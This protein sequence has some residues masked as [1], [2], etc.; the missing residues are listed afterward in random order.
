MSRGEMVVSV[1]LAADRRAADCKYVMALRRS[2]PEVEMRAEKTSGF[3]RSCSERAI[4]SRRFVED[5]SSRGLKRNLEHREARGSMILCD[6]LA[7][8]NVRFRY[9]KPH[10]P[11]NIIA[12]QAKTGY[13]CIRLHDSPKCS[14]GVLCHTVCFVK[15]NNFVGRTW[16]CLAV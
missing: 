12:N 10:I 2:P 7:F 6:P 1:S 4:C 13:M 5:E 15:N 8:N 3:T 11:C 16:V 9:G 14:L